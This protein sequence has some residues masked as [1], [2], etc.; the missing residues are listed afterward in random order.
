MSRKLRV[1]GGWALMMAWPFLCGY[2]YADFIAVEW[3]A[4]LFRQF[5]FFLAVL[6]APVLV[7][8]LWSTWDTT[9]EKK[10]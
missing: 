10:G 9:M 5:L 6:M 8:C 2:L 1:T 7:G 3:I 4:A